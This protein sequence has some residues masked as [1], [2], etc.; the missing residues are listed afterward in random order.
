MIL[1]M[2]MA[3]VYLTISGS[4]FLLGEE[5][6]RKIARDSVLLLKIHGVILNSDKVLKQL[7]KYGNDSKIKAVVIRID[8]PGGV[9][10]SS[11]EYFN[12]IKK[13][14]AETKKPVIVSCGNLAASGAYYT[15]VAADEIYTNAGTLMGSIGV[16]MEFAN[17][18]GLFDW[19]KVKFFTIKTG[20]FKDS[21]S[22]HRPMRDDEKAY[23]QATIDE[24]HRQFKAAVSEGRKLTLDKV[25]PFADGRV[26]TGESAVK[27]GFADKIGG[28]EDAIKS[29]ATKSGITGKPEVFEPPRWREHF[30]QMFMQED[31]EDV[32]YKG[33]WAKSVQKVLQTELI[34]KPLFL[35][36]GVLEGT[37]H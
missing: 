33:D 7:N 37:T 16:I 6:E 22:N 32:S 15:A 1:I 28:L 2:F 9:V 34:G 5:S 35:M 29:A 11:Q 19:A 20:P 21:G 27:N 13:F 12:G 4:F 26:F 23:F 8:S 31:D 3:G 30:L 24:V 10:G 14:R 17:M 36:P 25:E 18:Q